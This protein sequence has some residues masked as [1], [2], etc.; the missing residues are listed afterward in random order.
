MPGCDPTAFPNLPTSASPSKEEPLI[1]VVTALAEFRTQRKREHSATLLSWRTTTTTT[2][3]LSLNDNDNAADAQS[4]PPTPTTEKDP[5]FT[6][7]HWKGEIKIIRNPAPK[8]RTG[9]V[10]IYGNYFEKGYLYP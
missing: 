1:D 9:V 6:E 4:H 5:P 3:H 2:N 10:D 8:G 7:G